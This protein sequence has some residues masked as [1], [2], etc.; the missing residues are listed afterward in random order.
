[1]MSYGFGVPG[2]PV[3]QSQPQSQPPQHVKG[4]FGSQPGD[5]Y[6]VPSHPAGNANAYMVYD[7]EGPREHH[8]HQSPF[9]PG[10]YPP[11]SSNLRIR[12][13]SPPHFLRNNP[14]SELVEKLV[15]MGYRGEHVVNV[16]Q[17]MEENGQP[18]DFNSVL[19][20]LNGHSSSG[21]QRGG[22]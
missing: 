18:V 16:I 19:D 13:S 6:P 11:S 17:R 3:Q 22:W 5:G 14:Y 21:G 12:N 8:P 2:I 10:S 20:R 9:P 4:A 7:S 1:M 15:S